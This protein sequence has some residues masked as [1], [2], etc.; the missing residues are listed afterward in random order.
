M[1]HFDRPTAA[2]VMDGRAAIST[3]VRAP[4]RARPAAAQVSPCSG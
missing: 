1:P 4:R 2:N 3:A